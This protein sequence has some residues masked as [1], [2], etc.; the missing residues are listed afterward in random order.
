MSS[1][2]WRRKDYGMSQWHAPPGGSVGQASKRPGASA[3][4]SGTQVLVGPD[5]K[6]G[7]NPW[8][9]V[10]F[11]AVVLGVSVAA[12]V[13]VMTSRDGTD[14]RD[15][16]SRHAVTTNPVVPVT[17]APSTTAVTATTT[18]APPPTAPPTVAPTVPPTTVPQPQVMGEA[19]ALVA[20][21]SQVDADASAAEQ[22]VG[23]WVPQLSSKNLGLDVPRDERGPY[24]FAMI[25]SD[26]L[27]YR[28][29][30]ASDGVLLLRSG[31]FNYQKGNYFVTVV[32]RPFQT[33]EAANGWC[34]ANGIG[35]GDC[36]AK[37]LAHTAYSTGSVRHRG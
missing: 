21:G 7:I 29:R 11:S 25:L 12:L 17:A 5:T 13:L 4:G 30:Y 23:L 37:Q 34:D 10:V 8:V 16:A 36:Y 20:L 14:G 2:V 28:Q 33:A 24:T 27:A 35:G 1:W 31:D 18:P 9:L 6:T 22:L 15:G 26:H 32:A 3:P 19:D